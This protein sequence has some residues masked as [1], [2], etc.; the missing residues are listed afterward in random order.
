MVSKINI[1]CLNGY[2]PVYVSV[3]FGVYS[4]LFCNI[5]NFIFLG[6]TLHRHTVS[7]KQLSSFTGEERPLH[8]LF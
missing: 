3:E 2:H 7:N 1:V 5:L 6:F 4:N 8:A